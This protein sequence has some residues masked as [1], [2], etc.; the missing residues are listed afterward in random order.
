MTAE[1]VSVQGA[2]GGLPGTLSSQGYTLPP[3]LPYEEWQ[4]A[5]LSLR[6][7]ANNI[8][9][10]VGDWLLYGRERYGQ[11]AYQAT[12]NEL[13]ALLGREADTLGQCA[14]V[15]SRFPPAARVPA[16]SWS[17][18]R[19]VLFDDLPADE[20]R[21]LLAQAARPENAWPVAVLAE[22]ARERATAIDAGARRVAPGAAGAADGVP[23]REPWLPGPDDLTPEARQ[24][25]A[26]YARRVR[27]P[28]AAAERVWAVALYWSG[29]RDAFVRWEE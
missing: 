20:G 26:L 2:P 10:W 29:Q 11:D 15:A 17:H 21:A 16:L 27:V 24:A 14:W 1:L 28:P 4:R 25:C 19:A 8:N 6:F 3:G 9:W 22:R 5:G 12:C 13:T 23:E 18:H 7:M